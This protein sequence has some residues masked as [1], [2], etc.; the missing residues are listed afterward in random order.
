MKFAFFGGIAMRRYLRAFITL[1]AA[2]AVIVGLTGASLPL[3]AS[4]SEPHL[5]PRPA[6]LLPPYVALPPVLTDRQLIAAAAPVRA[7]LAAKAT[8]AHVAH[9][10]VVAAASTRRAELTS[11]T[12]HSVHVWTAGFQAQV[13][14]CRGGVDLTGAYHTRTVGEHWSCGGSSFPESAGS[15][16]TFTG[17]D[18]GTYR[19]IGVVA[20]LN[21]YVAH[22]SNIPHGYEMLFQT[23][24]GGNSRYT[25]FI[26]LARV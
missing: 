21:A 26:A 13:N 4:A 18:A 17:L 1:S 5:T 8:A 12:G 15:L 19:V 25:I 23:C 9:A 2:T 16:V 22:T 10:R 7:E 20:T 14:A 11:A 24:R 6:M 3:A